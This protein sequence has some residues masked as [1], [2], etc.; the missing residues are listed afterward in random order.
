MADQLR[1]KVFLAPLADKYSE[2]QL[3]AQ[4]LIGDSYLFNAEFD[5]AVGSYKKALEISEV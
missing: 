1:H 5:K 2:F 4:K 3:R